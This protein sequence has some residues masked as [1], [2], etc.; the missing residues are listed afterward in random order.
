MPE[1]QE[2]KEMSREEAEVKGEACSETIKNI[3]PEMKERIRKEAEARLG[4]PLTQEEL[5]E[6]ADERMTG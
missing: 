6:E 3:T 4:R 1:E 2:R 5:D